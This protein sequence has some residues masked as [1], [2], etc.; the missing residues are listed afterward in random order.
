MVDVIVR[1]QRGDE[2]AFAI[3]AH[4]AD[5]RFHKVATRI[6]RDLD[7]AEDAIQQ[8]LVAVWRD[9]PQLRDPSR[10]DAWSHRLLVRA[11][12][13]ESARDRAA[14]RGG[15]VP[16][17]EAA[18]LAEGFGSI[19]DRDELD[20][21]FRRLTREHR[22]VVVLHHYLGLPLD[23]VARTLGIPAG[24]VRSRLHHAMRA[25]RAALEADS[26][27]G[28]RGVTSAGPTKA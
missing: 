4:G 16:V 15:R 25:L 8:A 20:R 27:P 6:L 24:T 21:G 13:L 3:L 18:S 17:T 5:A 7:A 10:F 22:A 26:R 9:L 19:I 14:R 1:A 12:Y 2:D 11:C 28:R 23:E